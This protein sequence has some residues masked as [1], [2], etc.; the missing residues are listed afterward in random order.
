MSSTDMSQDNNQKSKQDEL[1]Q[2]RARLSILQDRISAHQDALAEKE[3]AN[4]LKAQDLIHREHR[5][6][7][8]ETIL[9]REQSLFREQ[10][11]TRKQLQSKRSS[12]VA[13]ILLI[14]C[15]AAGYFAFENLDQQRTYFKQVKAASA[16]VDKLARVL[17]ITQQKMVKASSELEQKKLELEQAKELVMNLLGNSQSIEIEAQQTSRQQDLIQTLL[18]QSQAPNNY[19]EALSK[20]TPKTS[21]EKLYAQLNQAGSAGSIG[22]AQ[23]VDELHGIKRT[24]NENARQLSESIDVLAEREKLIGSLKQ[25]VA[26]LSEE[27]SSLKESY[28]ILQ[29]ESQALDPLAATPKVENEST[30]TQ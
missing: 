5:L 2:E 13:P 3:R 16:N 25:N 7:E 11:K 23:Q 9:K 29:N 15:V 27:L 6:A 1:A 10:H 26:M 4:Q 14:A 12:L 19:V 20:Q 22:S 30:K 28:R 17:G 8:N 21:Y 24:L 18:I